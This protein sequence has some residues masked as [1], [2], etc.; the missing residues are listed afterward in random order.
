MYQCKE[1]EG[2]FGTQFTNKILGGAADQINM[3]DVKKVIVQ[4]NRKY[5]GLSCM[6][7]GK[8][9]QIAAVARNGEWLRLWDMALDLGLGH[10]KRPVSDVKV[11]Q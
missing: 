8:A 10:T 11:D 4:L 3:Q 2:G 6:C 9:P 1:L 5:R 7:E